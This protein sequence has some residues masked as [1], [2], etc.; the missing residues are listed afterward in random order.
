MLEN[1]VSPEQ[2][3]RVRERFAGAAAR[4][5]TPDSPLYAR[6]APQIAQDPDLP[7][8][9]VLARPDQ[10]LPVFFFGAVHYLLLQE[11]HHPLAA[12]Y[13]SLGGSAA[14]TADPYPA[15]RAFCLDHRDAIRT[16]LQTQRVQTNEVRRCACLLPVFGMVARR[17]GDRPLALVEV[18]ASA[19][20]NLL[21]DR[22]GY[23]YGTGRRYGDPDSPVQL[24][25]ELRGPHQPPLPATLPPVATRLGI[26]LNPVDL[27]DP[28]A[29]AW[30]RALIWPEHQERAHLLQ[31]ALRLA[32]PDPPPLWAGDALDLLPRALAQAPAAATLC[33]WHSYTLNQ[34]TAAA[35]AR[36]AAILTEHSRQRDLY[37]ISMEGLMLGQPQVR[38]MTYTQGT[39]HEELL[40]T[41]NPHGRWLEW[42]GTA[43]ERT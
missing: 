30:L 9:A 10:P 37:R 18:G 42:L 21:W 24:H 14:A 43:E 35:R 38:L 28:V 8:L 12:F 6:L 4:E 22:Y 23:D 16:V 29:G 20:L 2:I 5:F 26:D 34:F 19:G 13:P 25:C 3:E 17:G 33:I 7:A 41:C 1:D 15:F 36:F 31:A 32:A 27:R 39:A 11:P 40:A